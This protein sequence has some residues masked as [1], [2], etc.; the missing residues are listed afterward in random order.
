LGYEPNKTMDAL[1][2]STTWL[3]SILVYFGLSGAFCPRFAP[4]V[5]GLTLSDGPQ[6]VNIRMGIMSTKRTHIVISEQLA[7]AIDRVV[8]KRG[9]SSFL[10]QAAE[11]E[12]LRLRQIKAL[13]AA[14]GAWKDKD[15]PELKEGS[16]AWVKKIR[17][18]N[19]R[20]SGKLTR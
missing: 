17:I 10:A 11:R 14:S 6:F 4:G 3:S 5:D 16:A 1:V 18:E 19:E 7:T 20:R 13:N 15:H 2:V 9:R 12:L 8:G